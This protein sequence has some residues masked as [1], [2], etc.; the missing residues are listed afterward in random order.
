MKEPTLLDVFLEKIQFWKTIGDKKYSRAKKS[1]KVPSTAVVEKKH[2]PWRTI[3]ALSFALVGQ[4]LLEPPNRQITL[5]VVLYGIAALQF[6]SAILAKEWILP[7]LEPEEITPLYSK[8]RPFPLAVSVIFLLLAFLF[9]KDN[10]FT[11][12][13]LV[14]WLLGSIFLLWAFWQMP[15]PRREF[16]EI[17]KNRIAWFRNLKISPWALLILSIFLVVVFF[18][19][20][21]LNQIPGEMFSDHAEKLLDV[22]DILHGQHSIFFPRNT[23]REAIQFYWTALIATVLGTGLSFVSLKIGTVLIGL[24]TLPFIYLLGKEIANKWAGLAAMFLAGVAYW[25]NVISRIGLRF[26]LY[27]LFVAPT[28]YFLIRGIR[29]ANRNLIILSGIALGIGLHGYSPFRLVPV[30]VVVAVGIFLLHK[31]SVG[32]K[33]TYIGSLILLAVVAF[34]IFLPLFRYM[35]GDPGMFSMRALSRISAT[36]QPLPG[37][38]LLIFIKNYWKA[39]IMFFY[40]NGS[41]WV[42]SVIGRPALDFVSAALYFLGV[43]TLLVR[44]VRKRNWVD[45]F[46]L[47]SIPLL[48]MPSILSLAFPD[49]NPSLNRTAGVIIPV[50][51]TAGIGLEAV[52][53]TIWSNMKHMFGKVLWLLLFFI[54]L[55]TMLSN[56]YNLVFS[57]FKTNFLAGAWN[58]S[59]I[60]RVI[61]GFVDT[62]GTEDTAYVVPYPY[63]VDTRLVGINAGFPEK[64]YALWPDSFAETKSIP[65]S[66]LFI[67][68]TQDKENLDTLKSLYPKAIEYYYKDDLEG[69]DFIILWLTSR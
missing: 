19:I 8:V 38:A 18:R 22:A 32:R 33:K 44:Y 14:L 6:L 62:I 64:D 41:I 45:L 51:V 36:E 9:F 61:R 43:L 24:M 46:L 10:T 37:S 69:K 26:P 50:F 21:Q 13:N 63:W 11:A 42:H 30:I 29:K 17:V 65:G 58:T 68:N 28:L 52:F 53:C 15:K 7:A 57:K 3:V 56:N 48:L 59:D 1:N 39:S 67:L 35:L 5:A 23:G 20:Y 49:E 55:I 27:P 54:M 31:S 2:F 16:R 4:R 60:G 40:D 47:V 66:K 25:P 34:T 12:F